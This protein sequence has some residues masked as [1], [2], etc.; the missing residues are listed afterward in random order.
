[1]TTT[2]SRNKELARRLHEDGWS[3]NY[4]DVAD[5]LVAEEYVEHSTAHPEDVHGPAGFKREV[6][7]LRAAFPDLTVTEEETIAEGDRVVSR[8][9]FQGTHEGEFQG[10]EPTGES[11][12]SEIIAINRFDDGKVVEAWVQADVMGLMQQLGVVQ[13]PGE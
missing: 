1:M 2:E 11:I 9:T 5:E 10:I 4:E 3:D 13:S 8:I 12:E 6:E 7:E